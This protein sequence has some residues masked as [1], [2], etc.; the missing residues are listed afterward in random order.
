MEIIVGT[1]VVVHP[2]IYYMRVGL[3]HSAYQLWTTTKDTYHLLDF[4]TGRIS[5]ITALGEALILCWM[6]T[7]GME[8]AW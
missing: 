3:F 4:A 8:G 7:Y 6:S 1:A 5:E 2:R